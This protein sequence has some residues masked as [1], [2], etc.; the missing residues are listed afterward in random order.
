M[1]YAGVV[2][3]VQKVVFLMNNKASLYILTLFVYGVFSVFLVVLALALYERLE[4]VSPPM[5][6]T[7]TAFGMI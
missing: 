7:A 6:Q 4:A 3:P 5:M 1:D 2:E